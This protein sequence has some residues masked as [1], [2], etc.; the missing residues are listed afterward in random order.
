MGTWGGRLLRR[1]QAVLSRRPVLG[2]PHVRSAWR[3]QSSALRWGQ[4][5]VWLCSG[6]KGYSRLPAAKPSG[7][8][9]TAAPSCW[10]GPFSASTLGLAHVPGSFGLLYSQALANLEPV[11]GSVRVPVLGNPSGTGT[12][13]QPPTCA[14]HAC[15]DREGAR[16]GDDENE[17]RPFLCSSSPQARPGRVRRAWTRPQQRSCSASGST[18]GRTTSGQQARPTDWGTVRAGAGSCR[19]RGRPPARKR[20]QK[21]GEGDA[22]RQRGPPA[23]PRPTPPAPSHQAA[24]RSGA[25]TARRGRGGAAGTRRA[26]GAEERRRRGVASSAERGR[27]DPGCGKSRGCSC[28]GKENLRIRATRIDRKGWGGVGGGG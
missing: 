13:G 12:D 1:P 23:P 8:Q 21:R 22:E 9:P 16:R 24:Q 15:P 25:K 3:S 28:S 6:H 10:P 7:G 19:P 20:Q 27:G 4:V 14:R 11:P 17:S 26:G 18:G 2:P 5:H